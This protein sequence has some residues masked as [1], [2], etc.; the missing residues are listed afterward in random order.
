MRTKIKNFFIRLGCSIAMHWW[1]WWSGVRYHKCIR[2]NIGVQECDKVITLRSA[3]VLV[4]KLYSSFEYTKDGF[5]ELY[6]AICPPP[7]NY[8]YYLDGK[9]RDDCDGFHSLS[10][11]CFYNSDLECYLLSVV[12]NKSHCVLLFKFEN[13]WYINDYTNIICESD[14]AQETIEL[15]NDY[16]S[17][18]YKASSVVYNAAIR[19]D[20]DKKKFYIKK[21]KDIK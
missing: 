21:I 12:A 10:Y 17:R 11:H 7:Q 15:Y 4:K 8:Q 19:Y 14:S 2:N 3:A 20:Y 1:C 18:C 16:F 6:D 9:V 13:R 5:T